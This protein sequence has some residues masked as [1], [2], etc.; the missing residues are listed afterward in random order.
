MHHSNG[1]M[2]KIYKGG[3]GAEHLQSWYTELNVHQAAS[4]YPGES[5]LAFIA[6]LGGHQAFDT[7]SLALF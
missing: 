6:V 4:F 1:R 5:S 2:Q 7:V 3:G